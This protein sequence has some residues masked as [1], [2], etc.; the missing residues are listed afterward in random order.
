MET[1]KTLRTVL[2][3]G[4]PVRLFASPLLWIGMGGVVACIAILHSGGNLGP[5]PFALRFGEAFKSWF[6]RLFAGFFW[7]SVALAA[8]GL[9]LG[10]VRFRRPTPQVRA[11][12]AEAEVV[13]LQQE[14]ARLKGGNPDHENTGNLQ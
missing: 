13:R 8:A 14:L 6:P 4:R 7:G 11:A 3:T 12:A 9:I 1:K 2:L 5:I 10:A